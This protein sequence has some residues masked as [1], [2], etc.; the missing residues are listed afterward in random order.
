MIFILKNLFQKSTM[1]QQS[2]IITPQLNRN[3]YAVYIYDLPW[4]GFGY[5]FYLTR[6]FK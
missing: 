3:L 5:D 2:W 1:A 4:F 6:W